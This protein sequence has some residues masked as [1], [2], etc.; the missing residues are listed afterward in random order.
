[1]RGRWAHAR[2]KENQKCREGKGRC[3]RK[4]GRTSICACCLKAPKEHMTYREVWAGFS[5]RRE[6]GEGQGD[7]RRERRGAA[8]ASLLFLSLVLSGVEN[9][10]CLCNRRCI[11]SGTCSAFSFAS[12]SGYEPMVIRACSGLSIAL[13]YTSPCSTAA[14]KPTGRRLGGFCVPFLIALSACLFTSQGCRG[15]TRQYFLSRLSF[16]FSA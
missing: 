16:V 11:L 2:E 3:R 1:M 5:L 13:D 15:R 6:K 9:R 12:S 4:H 14:T 7:L 8:N 10:P